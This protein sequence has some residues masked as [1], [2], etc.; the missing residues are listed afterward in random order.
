MQTESLANTTELVLALELTKEGIYEKMRLFECVRAR[1][2]NM[3][4]R[5]RKNTFL[6]NLLI[7]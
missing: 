4:T 6:R 2:F 1:M 7:M 5:F 3:G